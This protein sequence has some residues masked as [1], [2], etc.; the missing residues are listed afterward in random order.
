MG[1]YGKDYPAV[2]NKECY[3]L[4]CGE[5]DAGR[6]GGVSARD[7]REKYI[8]VIDYGAVGETPAEGR[9]SAGVRREKYIFVIGYGAVSET[10]AEGRASAGKIIERK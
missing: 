8:F 2:D 5:R 4:W 3:W 7:W 6:G 10:P 1:W 9:A